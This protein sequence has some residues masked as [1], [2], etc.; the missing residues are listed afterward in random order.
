MQ[1]IVVPNPP[2][3]FKTTS[4]SKRFFTSEEPE[5]ISIHSINMSIYYTFK[6]TK[7]NN[8]NTKITVRN[9]CQTVIRYNHFISRRL[10]LTPLNMLCFA[11]SINDPCIEKKITK[12]T[13]NIKSLFVTAYFVKNNYEINNKYKEPLLLQLILYKITFQNFHSF[14]A[15]SYKN[16]NLKII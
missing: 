10:D 16:E 3:S 14:V 7:S 8:Q 5:S 6:L 1:P 15:D 9:W 2:L 4:L 11:T 12:P 13:A